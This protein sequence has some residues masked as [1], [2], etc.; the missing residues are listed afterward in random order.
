MT[1]LETIK[2]EGPGRSF[3]RKA[4]K[5][6][7]LNRGDHLAGWLFVL[8]MVLGFILLLLVPLI[9][10]LYMSFT[11]WPLLG[12]AKLIGFENY[13]T[14]AGDAEFWRVLGN[15]L[16]FAVGLV[17]LNITLALLLAIPLS[18]NI[19]GAGFFRTLIFIPV[20][21]SLVVWS[22]VW[23]YM[24]ATDS[25]FINQLLRMI[26]ITGPAWLY[27]TRLAMPV[28]IVTSLLKNVGLNMVLFIAA[29]QQVPAQLYE[30]ARIDG[31]GRMRIFFR[32]TVPMITPTIFLTLMMTIIGS[33]K[34]FGQIYVM[35]QGGPSGS[36][37]VLVYN[38][39]ERAFKLFEFGYASALAYV[40][41]VITLLLTLAQ[42]QMR[43]RWVL[44]ES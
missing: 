39:W 8:P 22:I 38:I 42:W 30:A 6:R 36:T 18:K 24:F 1:T 3:R 17:P 26:G 21:T 35:T 25:G 11:D 37:K 20:M 34:V 41:F 10:A 43:K 7:P 44:N 27:D 12:E 23:K 40:L 4:R 28:V 29:L 5:T 33:L 9:M 13:R 15:T 2:S 16:Y 19:R 14:I 31:A 32:I